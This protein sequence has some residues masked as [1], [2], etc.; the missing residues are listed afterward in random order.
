MKIHYP[1][2]SARLVRLMQRTAHQYLTPIA[3]GGK[4][5]LRDIPIASGE[6]AFHGLHRQSQQSLH[7]RSSQ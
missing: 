6:G 7:F 1:T 3:G 4:K 5:S 2:R